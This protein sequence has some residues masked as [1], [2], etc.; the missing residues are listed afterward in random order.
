MKKIITFISILF[1]CFSAE[2]KVNWIKKDVCKKNK[3]KTEYCNFVG[4]RLYYFGRDIGP[5]VGVVY[6]KK[7]KNRGTNQ[8]RPAEK[9]GYY[10]LIN[11]M[12]DMRNLIT[13][14]YEKDSHEI[15]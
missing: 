15:K 13:S 6:I 9:T 14:P 10:L 3:K 7:G 8:K 2:A 4:K 5:I 11:D 1:V 12:G